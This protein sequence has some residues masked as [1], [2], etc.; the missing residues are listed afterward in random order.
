MNTYTYMYI[1]RHIHTLH[2]Y[3]A[4]ICKHTFMELYRG[5]F[6]ETAPIIDSC[7]IRPIGPMEVLE[8]RAVHKDG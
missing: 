8:C 1:Y 2:T 6:A 3:I 5:S 7:R 4:Y